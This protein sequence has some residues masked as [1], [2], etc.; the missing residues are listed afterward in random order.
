M[1]EKEIIQD[2]PTSSIKLI[3]GQRGGYGWE[4]K[5]Y[6]NDMDAVLAEVDVIDQKMKQ[7]WPL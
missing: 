7:K 4:I 1:S 2:A 5:V 6:G 3:K